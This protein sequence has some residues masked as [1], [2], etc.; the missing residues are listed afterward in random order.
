[1]LVI[2]LG[3][4]GAFGH[5]AAACLVIDG[6]MVA[7][8]EEERF[9]RVKRAPGTLPINAMNYCLTHAGA[10][11]EEVD[12]I[13][14]SWNQALASPG[15]GLD[16]YLDRLLSHDAWRGHCRPEV[17]CVDH[18]VAHAA[19][20]FLTSGFDEAAV[21]VMDGHSENGST[22]L[23]YGRGNRVTIE[24]YFPIGDSLGHFF[25]AVGVHVGLGRHDAGKLMGLAA[26]GRPS[27]PPLVT[28]M[29]DGYRTGIVT[30]KGV[31]LREA[32]REAMRLWQSRLSEFCAPR[33]A[34]YSLTSPD[35]DFSDE[36]RTLAATAQRD[37]GD[38]VIHLG[39]LAIERYG[40][41]NLAI[42]G[43]VALN[44]TAN[45]R[46]TAEGC[47]DRLY[48]PPPAHDAGGALGAALLVAGVRLD[49]PMN[50]Y[51]GPPVKSLVAR[52]ELRRSDIPFVTC[53]NPAEA[54]ADLLAEGLV[55]AWF[56]DRA[57]VGPRALGARSLLALPDSTAV[58]DRVNRIKG[59]ELWRPLSPSMLP[60]AARR[61]CTDVE[62]SPYMLLATRTTEAACG[63]IPAVVHVDGTCRPQVV[64]SSG[65]ARF[66]DLIAAVG[67][68]TGRGVV[69]NTSLNGPD[70]PIV[71]T[72]ADAIR[73][74]TQSGTD[75][76]VVDNLVARRR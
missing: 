53:E 23:G 22:S 74:F 40:T 64:D 5:D 46:L 69:L 14:V 44:C 10:G 61:Y 28:L 9:N 73:F 12:T 3:V 4:S 58:R 37:L 55:V 68:R 33:L 48:I 52:E 15:S 56:Q 20:S 16:D 59:R 67:D 45:G 66:R 13:A 60:A 57:E 72:P 71:C 17:H 7:M 19:S 30:S 42:A 47:V 36:Q 63:E 34:P 21:L 43:G 38:A 27:G 41:R 2:V 1:M 8:G 25:E 51:L 75:A 39:K 31:P 11:F 54:A 35:P 24:E 29:D 32:Y 26:Y 50:P 62:M 49:R 70:E 6:E 65:T 76:L 18:H